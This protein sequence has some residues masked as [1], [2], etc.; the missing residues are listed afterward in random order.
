MRVTSFQFSGSH[1]YVVSITPKFDSIDGKKVDENT[2]LKFDG[3]QWTPWWSPENRPLQKLFEFHLRNSVFA[4][5]RGAGS[6]S[7]NDEVDEEDQ[8]ISVA[9]KQI[10]NFF[11]GSYVEKLAMTITSD[12]LTDIENET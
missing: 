9:R 7:D 10:I 4:H 1:L 8:R 12:T 5:M 11:E 3:S 6:D 2:R